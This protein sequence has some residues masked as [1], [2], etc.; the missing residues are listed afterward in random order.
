MGQK[1]GHGDRPVPQFVGVLAP[2]QS[3]GLCCSFLGGRWLRD[4]AQ[5]GAQTS[6]F[7]VGRLGPKRRP[8][9]SLEGGTVGHEGEERPLP[10]SP[11]HSPRPSKPQPGACQPDFSGFPPWLSTLSLTS[12]LSVLDADT[13]V[14][15]TPPP[16]H[17]STSDP[18]TKFL[19]NLSLPVC[20]E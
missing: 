7:S 11:P 13:T 2:W 19:C 10:G 12:V 6:C 16:P 14:S 17:G 20:C 8:T 3:A 9:G 15:S 5:P 1:P 4:R 18:E